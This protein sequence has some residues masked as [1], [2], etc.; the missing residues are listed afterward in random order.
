M[1][2]FLML[3]SEAPK[4]E[5]PA[6]LENPWFLAMLGWV[7]YNV[8]K[9][10][11]DQKKYDTDNNGL[12]LSEVGAYFRFNWIGMLFSLLLLP[13]VVP[14]THNIWHWSVEAAGYDW[15]FTKLAYG[16]IGFLMIGLQLL[17]KYIKDKFTPK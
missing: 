4:V 17:V 6:I 5:V 2:Q 10:F 8:G 1:I 16:L 9:L 13:L 3:F 11:I 14:Y 7:I 15:E 12:G